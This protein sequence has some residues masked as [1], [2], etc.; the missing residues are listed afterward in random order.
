MYS[1]HK[2]QHTL[3][4]NLCVTVHTFVRCCFVKYIFG[5]VATSVRSDIFI[6]IHLPCQ[7]C[8]ASPKRCKSAIMY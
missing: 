5:V 1:S 7:Q 2:Q 8:V 3:Q 6:N 4:N